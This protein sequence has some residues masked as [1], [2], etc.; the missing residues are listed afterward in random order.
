[1]YKFGLCSQ[2]SIF[3]L[4]IEKVLSVANLCNKH[5]NTAIKLPI[6]IM[7]SSLN[8]VIIKQFFADS[9]YFGYPKE[10]IFFFEQRLEPCLT[11][12]DGKIIIES[13]ESLSMA[14]D[15][16]GGI[17]AALKHSGC[18]EQMQSNQVKYVH[19]Y[20]VDNILTKACDPEFIGL[21]IHRNVECANKVVWRASKAEKVGVTVEV[22]DRMTIVEYSDISKEMAEATDSADKLLYGAANICNHIVSVDFIANTVLSDLNSIYHVAPK[23]IP[24]M[25]LESKKTIIPT[26]NNGA[27]MEMFI[28]DVFPL[29]RRWIVMEVDRADE[30]APIKNEPGNK[31]D[32]PDTARSLMTKQAY[33]WLLDAGAIL[34]YNNTVLNVDEVFQLNIIENDMLCE[35]SP[36]RSYR[37]ENLEEF[38]GKEIN[39]PHY[40]D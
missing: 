6:Y 5:N 29:A 31:V 8:D 19:I 40:I 12:L 7:T 23:K 26:V 2:K 13:P 35:I 22:N 21:S 4:H 36:L 11:L 25:D 38:N 34:K 1:M 37:G 28:F 17:Y 39:L 33:R 24:Y 16:N 32:S 30:F 9:N 18:L 14:P 15:G 10:L 27:K 3:Q 20:G